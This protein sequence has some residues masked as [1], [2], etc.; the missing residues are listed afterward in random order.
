MYLQYFLFCFYKY[1]PLNFKGLVPRVV[2][3][4]LAKLEEGGDQNYKTTITAT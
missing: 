3:S 2:E 1:T 4:L